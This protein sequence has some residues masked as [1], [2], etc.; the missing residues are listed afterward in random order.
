MRPWTRALSQVPMVWCWPDARSKNSATSPAAYTP[1]TFVSRYS[2]PRIP[3]RTWTGACSKRA[4]L[5][6]IQ[7]DPDQVG[8]DLVPLLRLHI[9]GHAMTGNDCLHFITVD[10]FHA[11]FPGDGINHL[12]PIAIQTRAEPPG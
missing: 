2:L 5:H 6:Q 9:A 8:L 4:V 1:G 10:D 12:P 11:K 3:L 7:A